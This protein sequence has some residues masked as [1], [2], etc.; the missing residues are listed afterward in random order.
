MLRRNAQAATGSPLIKISEMDWPKEFHERSDLADFLLQITWD[1]GSERETGSIS[2]F[3]QNGRVGACLTDKAQGRMAFVTISLGGSVLDELDHAIG[4]ED[5]VWKP[6]L[7][8]R[9]NK[10]K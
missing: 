10:P 1:D 8:G 3:S 6:Y 7:G 5:L 4:D 2:I 9:K